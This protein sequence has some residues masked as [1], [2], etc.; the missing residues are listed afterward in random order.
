M[1]ACFDATIYA[2]D[3]T[4]P[5]EL[6]SPSTVLS[7][8]SQE[9]LVSAP[10]VVATVLVVVT[11]PA[12]AATPA[13]VAPATATVTAVPGIDFKGGSRGILLC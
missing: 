5:L 9:L 13:V 3:S 10:F 6:S 4:I 1:S 12:V 2:T 11:A 8:P 7:A